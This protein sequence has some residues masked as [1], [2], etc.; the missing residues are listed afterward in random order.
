MLLDALIFDADGTLA[1]TEETHRQAF[2][3]AFVEHAL[4]WDWSPHQYT[5]LLLV[6][7]GKERLAT[8]IDSLPVP[9]K[10]KSR[11]AG[12]IPH[13]HRTKS[14]IY[15]E[16]LA[17]G[18]APLRTG[19]GRLIR[20]AHAAGIHLGIASTSSSAN[21]I[22]LVTAGLGVDAYHWFSVIISGDHV[23]AKKP[24]PDIYNLALSALRVPAQACI[25][26]ED[27]INGLRAAKAAGLFTVATP[28]IWTA[29]ED[30]SEADLLL[31][32]FGDPDIPLDPGAAQRLGAPF[33]GL[34][35]LRSLHAA[36]DARALSV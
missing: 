36:A 16:L 31:P 12:M 11:L 27:S 25:A 33:L 2:N 1:D 20:E 3:A 35:Q 14:R 22:A 28:T 7:G 9:P 5:G 26:F 8:Y 6:S 4:W 23:A 32:G 13:I 17:D 21:V 10:E 29:G 30:F 24:S 34:S 15:G 19:V 18:R